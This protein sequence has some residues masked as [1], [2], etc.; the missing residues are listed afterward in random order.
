MVDVF[1]K[2]KRS[3]IMSKVRSSNTTPEIVIKKL[4]KKQNIVFEM[5]SKDIFG[6]PDFVFRKE[7]LAIFIDGCFWHGCKIHRTI[8]E[9]NREFWKRKIDYNKKRRIKIKKLLM[10]KG[11]KVLEFW[12]HDV[13]KNPYE[14]VSKILEKLNCRN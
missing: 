4:L 12:E 9:T 14:V 1:S 2:K 7:K 13:N 10:K 3:E 8:P 11:W 5:Y 6:K